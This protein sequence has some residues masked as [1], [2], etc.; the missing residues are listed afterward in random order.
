M[1]KGRWRSLLVRLDESVDKI[2]LTIVTCCIMHNLSIEVRD[3]V[4]VDPED[5]DPDELPSFRGH[6]NCEGSRLRNKIKEA[7]FSN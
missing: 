3:D 5:D 7:Y 4:N 6:M 1:L 2:P